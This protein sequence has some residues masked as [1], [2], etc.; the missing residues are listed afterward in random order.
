MIESIVL[1]VNFEVTLRMCASG[2]YFGSIGANND[3][4]AVAA[5]PNLYFALLEDFCSFYIMKK[6]AIA[7]FMNRSIARLLLGSSRDSF[8]PSAKAQQTSVPMFILRIPAAIA[9]FT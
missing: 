6:C 9:A 1:C 2:A 5:F 3:V 8:V 7:F 4:T